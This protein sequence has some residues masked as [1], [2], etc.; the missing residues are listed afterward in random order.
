M[1]LETLVQMLGLALCSFL[2]AALL[3][4][5]LAWL[6]RSSERRGPS[7]FDL[8]FDE[9]VF[10]FEDGRLINATRAATRMLASAPAAETDWER[11]VSVF[12]SRFPDLDQQLA[13]LS[14]HQDISIESAEGNGRLTAEWF[15]ETTR[16]TLADL[17]EPD[18][19]NASGTP[20]ILAMERELETLRATAEFAPF[21]V[22]RQNAAGTVTWANNA[23]LALAQ[24]SD[25]STNLPV[26]PPARLFDL[27]NSCKTALKSASQRLTTHIEGEAE[28]RWFDCFETRLGDESLY[29]A[30]AADKVVK[31][32]IALRDFVQTLTKTFAH[33]TIGLAI[34]D[35]QRRL[36]LFNPAL[37]D[38]TTLSAAF[39][40]TRPTLQAVLDRL[41]EKKMLPEPKDYKSWRKR[42]DELEVAAVNG[43]YAETWALANG[44]TYRVTGRP[45]PDG[46]VAFLFEDISAEISSTRRFRAELKNSQAVLDALPE[47]IAL[48]SPTGQLLLSNSEYTHLWG[49]DPDTIL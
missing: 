40:S 42:L 26:W 7:A 30:V 35:K 6:G 18:N 47:A 14:A 49:I 13:D 36:A 4:M 39:L 22:W 19:Q 32:E 9:N 20:R 1:G 3:L 21:L 12:G 48:F 24:N 29:T 43:T 31:A 16:I 38:L 41:R 44:C 28:S 11:F 45:H 37:A 8:N 34:F 33:L 46:A 23:Y 2:G 10:L 5:T 25:G 15:E 27:T 17:S